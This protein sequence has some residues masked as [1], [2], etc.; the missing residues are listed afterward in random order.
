VSTVD[1]AEELYDSTAAWRQRAL[2]GELHSGEL[3]TDPR[4]DDRTSV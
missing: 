2:G 1:T 4:S 3:V